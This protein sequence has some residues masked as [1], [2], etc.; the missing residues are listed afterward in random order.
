MANTITTTQIRQYYENS[1][2][3]VAVYARGLKPEMKLRSGKTISGG[4]CCPRA[5]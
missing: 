5:S 1:R 4:Y 3:S 2:F